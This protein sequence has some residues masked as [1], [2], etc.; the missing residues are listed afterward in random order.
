MDEDK[1]SNPFL[2]RSAS[3]HSLLQKSEYGCRW[4]QTKIEIFGY[5]GMGQ[6]LRCSLKAS[7][8]VDD[9]SN[10]T[11]DLWLCKHGCISARAFATHIE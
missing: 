2:A 3:A 6:S 4:S 11:L 8:D 9:V 1:V 7:M 10:P 5:A